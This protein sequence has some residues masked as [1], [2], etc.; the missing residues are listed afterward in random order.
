MFGLLDRF[1][2]AGFPS[3]CREVALFES[4]KNDALGYYSLVGLC[5]TASDEEIKAAFRRE[6][7]KYHPDGSEPDRE[8]FE[9]V[10]KAY[11]T[12]TEDRVAYDSYE[13]PPEEPET[14][15]PQEMD[16]FQEFIE[17]EGRDAAEELAQQVIARQNG[18][19][20]YFLGSL[21]ERHFDTAQEWYRIALPFLAEHGI[22]RRIIL[23]LVP[24]LQQAELD[25]GVLLVPSDRVSLT[26]LNRVVR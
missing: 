20:Y 8:K 12:L 25:S 21:P 22:C 13:E 5:P 15:T 14:M 11:R 24:G 26:Y 18:W 2:G 6:L 1:D 10:E 9:Q 16:A 7:R 3:S 17:R 23:C 19:S 4:K